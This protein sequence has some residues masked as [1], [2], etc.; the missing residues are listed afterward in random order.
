M[1]KRHLLTTAMI[2][3]ALGSVVA[4]KSFIP[5]TFVVAPQT[6]STLARPTAMSQPAPIEIV[7]A[8]VIDPKAEVFIGTGDRSAGS[9]VKP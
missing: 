8:P 9:W 4:I 1:T 5:A 7:P 3:T 6:A 2:L